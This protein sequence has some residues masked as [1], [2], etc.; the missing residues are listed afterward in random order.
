MSIAALF[1]EL[2]CDGCGTWRLDVVPVAGDAQARHARRIARAAGWTTRQPRGGP[3]VDL[4]PA[5][6][7]HGDRL[8]RITAAAKERKRAA[9]RAAGRRAASVLEGPEL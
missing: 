4:C 2:A 5:C 8:A 7:D 9:C 6:R 3:R 1:V